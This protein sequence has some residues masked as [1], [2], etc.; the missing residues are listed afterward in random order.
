MYSGLPRSD[1][2]PLIRAV[3]LPTHDF[4]DIISRADV[5]LPV[6]VTIY[7]GRLMLTLGYLRLES[8][9]R[10]LQHRQEGILG[11]GYD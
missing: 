1:T 10:R 9:R 4:K 3:L 6:W 8:N 2:A 11:L 5:G 7:C